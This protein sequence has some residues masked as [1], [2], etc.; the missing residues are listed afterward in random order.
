[1]RGPS[2]VAIL[3][4]SACTNRDGG[5]DHQNAVSGPCWA[6]EKVATG[7]PSIGEPAFALDSSG[8]AHV[9]FVLDVA[10]AGGGY[11]SHAYYATDASGTWASSP[12]VDAPGWRVGA[13]AIDSADRRHVIFGLVGDPLVW[14]LDDGGGW[15]PEEIAGGGDGIVRMAL[16]S[17][18]SPVLGFAGPEGEQ[19]AS[20][21][22]VAR[23]ND[24]GW[25]VEV[26]DPSMYDFSP[27]LAVA[28]D[29]SIHL[30]HRH[31]AEDGGVVYVTNESGA[32]AVEML[33]EDSADD[34]AIAAGPDGSIWIAASF[35]VEGRSQGLRVGHRVGGEWT[36][37]DV[38]SDA[39]RELVRPDTVVTPSGSV[40]VIALD[41]DPEFSYAG[42]PFGAMVVFT[43]E[44]GSWIESP[45]PPRIQQWSRP[46]IAL[47][48][49]GEPAVAFSTEASEEVAATLWVGRRSLVCQ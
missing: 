9:Y 28:P 46:A 44:S 12:L 27:D 43:N 3:L 2:V 16:D 23:R 10:N 35:F 31:R 6:L 24:E 1:M 30:V 49:D 47:G 15:S 13:L 18:G 40:F 33:W 29:G 7:D 26:A 34:A 41:H 37:E 22:S 25:Q 38:V 45:L 42:D 14:A 11:G 4:L 17:A 36:W 20:L 8:A 21:L 39:H 32:W 48:P 19:M 5:G